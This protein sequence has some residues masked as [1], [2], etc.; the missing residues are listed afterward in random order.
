M[1]FLIAVLLTFLWPCREEHEDDSASSQSN[2][3]DSQLTPEHHL[4][5][6]SAEQVK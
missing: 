5:M 3:A 6:S 1:I 2:E 4:N